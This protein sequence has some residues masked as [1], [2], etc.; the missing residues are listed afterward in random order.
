MVRA[1]ALRGCK[2]WALASMESAT[3]GQLGL[4]TQ[5]S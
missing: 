1:I 2:D 4:T 3:P 5:G